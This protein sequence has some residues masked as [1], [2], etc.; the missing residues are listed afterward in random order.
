MGPQST[1]ALPAQIPRRAVLTSA[2]AA[3]VCAALTPLRTPLPNIAPPDV[4]TTFDLSVA[5]LSGL[6]RTLKSPSTPA[7][8]LEIE[9]LRALHATLQDLRRDYEPY[10]PSPSEIAVG[11][12]RRAP[13]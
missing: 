6:H 13:A 8:R 12:V 11:V 2:Q 10:S 9:A 1:A 3:S 7:L 4:G 5:Q